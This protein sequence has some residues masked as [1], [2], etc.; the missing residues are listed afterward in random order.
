MSVPKTGQ[1]FGGMT[2][3]IFFLQQALSKGLQAHPQPQAPSPL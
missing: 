3:E 2:L 1:V